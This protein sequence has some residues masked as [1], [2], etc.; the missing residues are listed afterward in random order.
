MISCLE[1]VHAVAKHRRDYDDLASDLEGMIILLDTH[2]RESGATSMSDCVTNVINSI[3]TEIEYI[4]KKRGDAV[5][6]GIINA[7]EDVED[8]VQCYRRIEALFRRLQVDASLSL[9]SITHEQLANNRLEAMLPS[10]LASYDSALPAGIARRTCTESTRTEILSGLSTWSHDLFAAKVY[11][12]NGMAGTGKTTIACSLSEALRKRKQ[13]GASFFCTRTLPECRDIR[14]IVPTLAYQLARYA[15]RF[16]SAL[17]RVLENDP[18]VGTRQIPLQFERMLKDPLLGVADAMPSNVVVVIDALDECD[19]SEGVRTLLETLFRFAADLPLKF[20][21]ASRPE[22]EIRDQMRS[23]GDTARSVLH[24]HEIER[25]LVQADIE[26][27]LREELSFMS[28]SDEQIKQL[29]TLAGNLFIYATTSVR[30][31]RQDSLKKSIDPQE[32]LQTVLAIKSEST[33]LYRFIRWW[34][35]VLR[36]FQHLYSPLKGHADPSGSFIT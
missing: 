11:W 32:R 13:L 7:G 10:K 26:L 25:S 21:V 30:Y 16:Q 23:L 31:I 29:A 20:F 22:P 2:L 28:P 24:L 15:R 18:D 36:V 4:V 17:C 35:T 12:M 8:L 1:L 34:M 27:Y 3:N 33:S 6:S 5:P 19:D 14:R 9:W